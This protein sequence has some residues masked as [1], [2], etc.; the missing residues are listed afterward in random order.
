MTSDRL[1]KAAALVDVIDAAGRIVAN[2]DRHAPAASAATIYA[3]ACAFEKA[4]E[5][6]IEGGELARLYCLP[7]TGNH[8]Q[9]DLRDDAMQAQVDHIR[10]LMAA[11]RGETKT[12]E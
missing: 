2:G 7:F 10:S 11:I 5:I 6:A 3:L 9:D 8:E 4:W 12:E 1:L